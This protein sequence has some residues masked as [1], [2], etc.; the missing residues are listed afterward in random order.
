MTVFGAMSSTTICTHAMRRTA[1]DNREHF[2]AVAHRV[3][4]NFYVDNYLD[5][6]TTKEEA[7]LVANQLITLLSRGGFRQNQSISSPRDVL[8]SIPATERSDPNLN[9]DVDELPVERTLGLLWD[10]NSDAF[11]FKLKVPPQAENKKQILAGVMSIIDPMGLLAPVVLQ[12]KLVLQ[13]LCRATVYWDE[14]LPP[15]FTE[16]WN[17]WADKLHVLASLRIPRVFWL[18]EIAGSCTTQLHLFSDASER[19]FGAVAY[20]RYRLKREIKVA[21]VAAKALVAPVLQSTIPKLG[22]G[23]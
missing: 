5:S 20:I 9:I 14:P 6:F 10:C 22:F 12:A 13:D 2:Q 21:F 19:G 8:A 1:E 15:E 18:E 11:Q 7:I 23:A 3:K 4:D 16:R 17:L